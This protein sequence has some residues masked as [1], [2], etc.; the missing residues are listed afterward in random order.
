MS[1]N[2]P[3]PTA[4]Q[5]QESGIKAA[6]KY[7]GIPQ[8]WLSKR[9]KLPSRNWLIFIGV[10][11]TVTGYYWYDRRQCK[12]I[13]QAYVDKVKDLAEAPLHS[14]D[15]PRKVTVYG[16]KWPDDEDSDRAIKYFRK[17]V[18]PILVAAAVD[19]GMIVGKRYGDITSRVA[20]EIKA[21]RRQEA[22]IDPIK[23]SLILKAGNQSPEARRRRELEGG[24][25][26][27]GRPTFKEF[28][29]GLRRGWTDGLEKVDKEDQLAREL[30]LDGKFDEVEEPTTQ[31][32]TE[33]LSDGEP[34]PTQSRLPPSTGLFTPPYLRPSP[35]N[36]PSSSPPSIPEHLNIPPASIPQQPP[37]L[38][39]PFTN[40]LGFLQLPHMIWDFF[41]QR[42]KVLSGAQ[43][44]YRLIKSHTR[45]L[46][47]GAD[48]GLDAEHYY[49]SSMK[50]Y[51]ESVEKIRTEYYKAL[52]DKLKTARDLA[53][54]KREP[55][56][57]EI[58]YPPPTEVE[59]RAERLKKELRWRSDVAG[60]DIIKPESPVAF[61][62]RFN[63]ALE[64]FVDPPETETEL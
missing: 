64:V 56:K 36:K 21:R 59:L 33:N 61:D 58:N 12:A 6:L 34:L 16:A 57:D 41:N 32:D 8:S 30:E 5:V 46:E 27:V 63:G 43:C 1:S 10:T 15:Y 50:K 60:W 40:N 51:A 39:V 11:S 52:P 37:I 38:F 22:G 31:V 55:T 24:V 17:Y 13:R 35:G 42:H 26:L 44:A 14:H 25:V 18:K 29:E 48:L 28:M 3:T 54:G 4:P 9:P 49:K 20:D 45:P 19:Y 7:T 53:R 62:E 23:Q 47:P 2:G